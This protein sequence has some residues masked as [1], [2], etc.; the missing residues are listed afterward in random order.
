VEIGTIVRFQAPNWRGA[1]GEV[2]WLAA[3]VIGQWPDGS[4]QL[5]AFHFEGS[6]LV[7]SF[8]AR[9]VEVLG[10]VEALE[11]RLAD[12]EKQVASLKPSWKPGINEPKFAMAADDAR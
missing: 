9:N 6:F 10:N 2:R 8:P 3:V 12:L 11:R 7:N 1:E 4:L 5:Y